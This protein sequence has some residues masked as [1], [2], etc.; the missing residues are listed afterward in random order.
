LHEFGHALS[1]YTNGSVVDLYADSSAGINNKRGN[2]MPANFAV[3]NGIGMTT[4]STRNGL[5]YP[6]SWQS[7]HCELIDSSF[8]AVM[9]NYWLAADG[10]PEHCQHDKITRQF[11][12]DRLRAKIAR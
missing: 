4:D 9:D 12:I 3:Y 5:G 1:S 11:L 8:P 6:G 2:P 7:Y 10:I